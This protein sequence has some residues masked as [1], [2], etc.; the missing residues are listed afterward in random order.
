MT[1]LTETQIF[2]GNAAKGDDSVGLL[3]ITAEDGRNGAL[4]FM[5]AISVLMG[6]APPA[7]CF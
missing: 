7:H 6:V 1:I 2:S 3:P 4:T 5:A